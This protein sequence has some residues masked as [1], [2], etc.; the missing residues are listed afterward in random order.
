MKDDHRIEDG[1][2]GVTSK[3]DESVNVS[4]MS[5]GSINEI[6]SLGPSINSVSNGQYWDDMSGKT[7][8]SRL[9][10]NAR[11]E[12]MDEVQKHQVYKK[13]PIQ[14]CWQET[15]KGPIGTRWIDINKG[16]DQNPEYRSRLVAQEIKQ[17][18]REDLFAA[19]PPL[20]AKKMLFSMAVTQGIGFK[21]SR[22]HGFKI[23]FIDIR[24]AYFHSK[25]RRRVFVQL[26][27]ED[28]QEGMCGMLL[29]AMYGTRDA[30][31][32]WEY[33]YAEF[34]Q[35]IGFK[36]GIANPCVFFNPS[37]EIRVVVHGD[38]FTVL[39]AEDNL[40]WFREQI[41]NRFEVK[42]RG[43]IGPSEKDSKSI[44]I[45]N[46]VVQWTEKG[47]EYEAD[48]RH[49]ELIIQDMCLKKESNGA[50]TPGVK[51]SSEDDKQN[52][53]LTQQQATQYRAMVARANY[54]AQD[55]SDIQFAVKELCRSMSGPTIANWE[56]LK[57]LGRYLVKHTRVVARFNYQGPVSTLIVWTDTDYAGC[58]KTRKST[59]GGVC[60]HGTHI[61]KSWSST[62]SVIAL[63]SGEAEYYGIV[64]GASI[65]LGMSSLC[66]DLGFNLHV[67]V[68]SDA[69]AA[70]GIARRRG[71][72]KVR[73]IEV[74]QLWVQDMVASGKIK[75]Q[76]V[77]GEENLSDA[78]TKHVNRALLEQHVNS[79]GQQFKEGRHEHMP[80]IAVQE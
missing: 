23:D 34:M 73:H 54:L 67:Q 2:Y 12:E 56:A 9:V 21:N 5:L 33:E 71:L 15:G 13:V 46:R 59:S 58:S 50:V 62:Q 3:T 31:Q 38:D 4:S 60:M 26:P 42:F 78:L 61:I 37:R 64:K 11:Q 49:A 24:R 6:G 68:N 16:D 70:C 14:Q 44:R 19:T 72:G 65:G 22:R 80:Q 10:Q 74:A 43:R 1:A 51:V 32:N 77:K 8:Q 63:S 27:E 53:P 66:I 79:T 7:L 30:A 20:E 76:K 47:I 40:N 57:R 25:A 17:D 35:S 48:Q 69:S 39:A 52:Q 28:A 41:Q 18:K 55:R 29:K 45:L 75:L 36:R